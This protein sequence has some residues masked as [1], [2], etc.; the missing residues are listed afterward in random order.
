[1]CVALLIA[2]GSFVLGQQQVMPAWMR[3]SPLLLV[4]TFAPLI[5]MAYWLVRIRLK[6][7]IVAKAPRPIGTSV[8]AT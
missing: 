3:G 5:V 2:A 7:G 8:S 6:N 4:P 1:M